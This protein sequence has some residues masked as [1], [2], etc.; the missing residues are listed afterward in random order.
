M[1]TGACGMSQKLTFMLLTGLSV[2]LLALSA[3]PGLAHGRGHGHSGKGHAAHHSAHHAGSSGLWQQSSG[4][5]SPHA[6]NAPA[7]RPGGVG[8]PAH[9]TSPT[10][11]TVLHS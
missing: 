1:K 3:L 2:A 5:A 8:Q 7:G 10:P 9:P 4:S 6:G 11:T